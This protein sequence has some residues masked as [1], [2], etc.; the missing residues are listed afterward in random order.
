MMPMANP[1]PRLDLSARLWMFDFDNTLAALEQTVDWAASRAELEPILRLAGCPA[2][3]FVEFP[4]GNLGLYNAV[5]QRLHA[6]AFTSAM[7]PLELLQRASNIIE[8]HELA[9]V[10]QA[11]PMPGAAQLLEQLARRRA[12]VVIVTSNSSR[13]V[14]RWLARS[15]LVYTVRTVV[16]RDSLLPLKPAPDMLRRALEHCKAHRDA[17]LFAGDSDADRLAALAAGV[18]FVAIARSQEQRALM[19]RHG[20][21]AIFESPAELLAALTQT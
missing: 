7:T 17:A 20:V 19:R 6:G 14:Y 18:R 8:H 10:D 16:G 1:D 5:L 15:R 12:N 9:G 13:T 21:G 2:E 3:L 11:Q 4:R